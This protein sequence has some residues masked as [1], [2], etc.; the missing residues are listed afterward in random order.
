VSVTVSLARKTPVQALPQLIVALPP[1]AVTT[2][3]P[4]PEARTTNAWLPAGT[5]VKAAVALR[6]LLASTLH[7]GLLPAP[8]QSPLQPENTL[9]AS[10]L[11]TRVTRD[12]LAKPAPQVLPQTMPPGALITLPLPEPVRAALT[13]TGASS[14]KVAPTVVAALTVSVQ[15]AVPLQAPDQPVKVEPAAA[16][17]V[18]VTIL[19]EA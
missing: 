13:V 12:P 15:G 6:A 1:E 3:V 19:P 18:S 16:E 8:A 2:P 17:A 10:A 4:A 5:V 9:P 14:A 7:T 11:A